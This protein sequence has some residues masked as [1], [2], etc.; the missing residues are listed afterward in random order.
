MT[1]RHFDAALRH[2]RLRRMA[3]LGRERRSTPKADNFA[4]NLDPEQDLDCS[5]VRVSNA[6]QA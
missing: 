5:S 6:Q 4:A 3:A 1:L 2:R